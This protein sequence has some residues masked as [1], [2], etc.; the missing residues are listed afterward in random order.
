MS[1]DESEGECLCEV[2]DCVLASVPN[3]VSLVVVCEL[4]LLPVSDSDFGDP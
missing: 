1:G 4:D 2:S 3:L